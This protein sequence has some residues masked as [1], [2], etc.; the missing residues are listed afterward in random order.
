MKYVLHVKILPKI[1]DFVEGSNLQ[2]KKCL[3]CVIVL[4]FAL[5][6]HSIAKDFF[7]GY[8]KCSSLN[9]EH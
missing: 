7:L 1:K 9:D 2:S 5:F 4:S 6:R 3:S 8:T